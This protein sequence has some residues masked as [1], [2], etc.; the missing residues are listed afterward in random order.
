MAL[1]VGDKV[2]VAGILDADYGDGV[3]HV[4]INLGAGP[5][6]FITGV[7]Q[8]Q[9]SSVVMSDKGVISPL[10]I[11][12]NSSDFTVYDSTSVCDDG[13]CPREPIIII[14]D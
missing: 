3:W 12:G 9:G 7:I 13:C 1:A 2:L 10:N 6:I 5:D 14:V 4:K 8:S 11:T